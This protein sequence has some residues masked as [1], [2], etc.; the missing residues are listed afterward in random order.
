MYLLRLDDASEY[1]DIHKWNQMENL[2]DKY[3]IKPIVGVI[4]HNEDEAFVKIYERDLKFWDKVSQWQK[5][6]W[7][8]A[9][10]GFNHVY[11]SSSGGVNPVNYRSEFAGISLEAQRNK[12][13]KGIKVFQEKA[14]KVKIFFPPSHTFDLNTLE[15]LKRESPI[16]IIN[17]TVSN[18]LYKQGD[19]YFIPQQCGRVKWLPFRVTTFCYHPNDI[20]ELEIEKLEKFIKKNRHKFLSVNDLPMINRELSLYDKALRKL[21]FAFRK[22]RNLLKGKSKIS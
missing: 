21:Y 16:R 12:I 15:A 11:T 13:A 4:P 8:I 6:D 10:H 18:D 19:F 5:K 14:V 17:D 22:V 20:N 2:L 3:N 9:L 1:M 7:E